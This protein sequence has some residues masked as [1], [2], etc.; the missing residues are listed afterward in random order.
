LPWAELE[1]TAD[2]CRT[3][4]TAKPIALGSALTVAFDDESLMRAAVKYGR[5]VVHTATLYRHL[6]AKARQG[7]V[8]LEVSVDE[9]DSPTSVAEHYYIAAE[10]KRLGVEWVSLAPRY[11]G[12]F[13]KGVDYIGDLDAF[14]RSFAGHV[15]VARHLG[16]Y[17]LSLHSGSDKF[18]IYPIAAKLAGDLIHVKTAG[19]SYLEALRVIAKIDP[20]LFRE[21][22]A[23]GIGRYDE[24]RA[25][26]HVSAQ[27]AKVPDPESV[28]DNDLPGVLDQFDARQVLHVSY[29][30]VLMA[31]D[32]S[33]ASRFRDRLLRV[34]KTD[35]EAHA[36]GLKHHMD[37]HVAPFTESN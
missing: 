1:T 12:A 26:Y 35:P 32:A 7:S 34:L 29:G 16:P 37:K 36:A 21:I 2:D 27:L 6:I 23:F 8:E 31:E 17:K 15:A 5:A 22:L 18:S 24:D 10:L 20:S 25:T 14:E 4:Y 3:R 33:G 11:V 28:A 9:T 13:E 19:T 30:S